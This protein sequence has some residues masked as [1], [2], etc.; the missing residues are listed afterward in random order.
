MAVLITGGCGLVGSNVAKA[1]AKRNIDC[2]LLDKRIM[3]WDFLEPYG[4]LIKTVEADVS[5]Y[6]ELLEIAKR[7]NIEGVVHLAAIKFDKDCR[8]NPLLAFGVNVSS[9]QYVLE[10]ARISGMKR[11]LVAS[12]A[13]VFG[14]WKDKNVTIRED[15]VVTPNGLYATTKNISEL[16]VRG[17]KQAYATGCA[18]FRVSRIY[19]PGVIV[20]KPES[21]PISTLAYKCV[22]EGN[23]NESSGLDFH[24]DFS[25]VEDVAEGIVNLYLADKLT[26]DL[27]HIA[28]GV[29]YNVGGV[30][31]ILK[32]IFPNVSITV[33]KGEQPY[34]GQAPIRGALN[35]ERTKKEIGYEVK[36]TLREGLIKYIDWLSIQKT[37]QQ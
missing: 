33:G 20:A 29:L 11:V 12:S 17:Y 37:K 18:S 24:A 31:S 7:Y 14:N 26:Y 2:L 4:E 27:Y 9:T 3:L 35:I 36:H 13:A 10:I 21:N 1:F 34:A 5:N 25:F 19:G 23:V 6:N 28:S 32:D 15:D 30:V 8:S 22:F 16:L